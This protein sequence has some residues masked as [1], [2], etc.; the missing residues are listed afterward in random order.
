[1]SSIT[2]S[3][4]VVQTQLD[5]YN[6]KDLDAWLDTYASDAKQFELGGKLLAQGHAEIRARTAQ[7]FAEPNLHAQ[8][9]KRVTMGN[10]VIDHE[11]VT[12][13]FPEGPG[14]VELVCVYVV[15]SG[16]IQ[17]ASF[18]FGPQVLRSKP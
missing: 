5:A 8:L 11:T 14:T 7:R 9:L 16:K 6:A 1:M 4:T 12:R 13:T 3:E 2:S 17:S 15:S 18:N 10:V